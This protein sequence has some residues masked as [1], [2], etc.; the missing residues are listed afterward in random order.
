MARQINIRHQKF[1]TALR[2]RMREENT[3][4]YTEHDMQ[5][6]KL[7]DNKYFTEA[8]SSLHKSTTSSTYKASKLQKFIDEYNNW[9]AEL[10]NVKNNKSSNLY[11]IDYNTFIDSLRKSNEGI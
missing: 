8:R 3:N 7:A 1:L 9:I 10:N 6:A 2:E 11:N 4:Y 5:L